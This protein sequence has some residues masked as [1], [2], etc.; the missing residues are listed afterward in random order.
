MSTRHVTDQSDTFFEPQ[1][2]RPKFD[3]GSEPLNLNEILSERLA[4]YKQLCGPAIKLTMRL[5]NDLDP[6]FS[7]LIDLDRLL[8]NLV[9]NARSSMPFGGRLELTTSNA[10]SNVSLQQRSVRL[11]IEIVRNSP[12]NRQSVDHFRYWDPK[13]VQSLTEC[14][15][16]ANRG[17]LTRCQPSEL[18]LTTEILLP[19]LNEDTGKKLKSDPER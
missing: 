5:A 3:G 16:S 19:S 2:G 7:R 18:V 12:E 9:M 17:I 13:L 6:V 15:V 8:L 14:L 10:S 11:Q 4:L 1:T